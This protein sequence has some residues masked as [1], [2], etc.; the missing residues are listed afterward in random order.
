[1]RWRGRIGLRLALVLVGINGS[2]IAWTADVPA[3]RPP[4]E[5]LQTGNRQLEPNHTA[6]GIVQA[7]YPPPSQWK[8]NVL[9]PRPNHP[10]V[11]YYQ[12]PQAAC[13]KVTRE[14][15]EIKDWFCYIK[16]NGPAIWVPRDMCRPQGY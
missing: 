8:D 12:L 15:H 11:R 14:V 2:T 3:A 9:D 13:R 7:S 10:P 1:M 5:I 4:R 16:G 6:S